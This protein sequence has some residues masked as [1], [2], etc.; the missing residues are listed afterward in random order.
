MRS[1][2]RKRVCALRADDGYVMVV[3][4]GVLL[5]ATLFSV[6][7]L[8][9]ADKD[10]PQSR[11][12]VDRKAAIGAAE[13]GL[14]YYQYHL[15]E[16]N[17]FWAACTN[18]ESPGATQPAPVNQAWNG[19]GSD[20]R[21]WRNVPGSTD[22]QYTLELL[23]APGKTACDPNNPAASMI[24]PGTGTFRI[25]ATGR[26]S[27]NRN[28]RWTYR[29]VVSTFRRRGFLD[30]L[31]FTDF[32]TSPPSVYASYGADAQA[33]AATAC[34]R[35]WRDGRGSQSYKTASGTTI[36]CTAIQFAPGDAIRG[37]MHTN[38]NILICGNPTFGRTTDSSGNAVMDKIE[39]SDPN[40]PG[41]RNACSGS[42]N[43][44]PS[45]NS[46]RIGT[47]VL[48]LPPS[49]STLSTVVKPEYTFTGT[50]TIR[51]SGSTMTVSDYG[52]P[53][54]AARNLGSMPF[55]DNG[56]IYVKQGS[57][58]SSSYNAT[59]PYNVPTGCAIA[60][61]SG[62]YSKSLTVA[63]E[64]DV[65]VR[66]L[67]S[68]PDNSGLVRQS[69]SDAIMGLIGNDHVRVYHEVKNRTNGGYSCSEDLTTGSKTNIRIDAA[70]LALNY[71][72]IVDNYYCGSPLG[73][74]TVNGVIAQR[75]RGPVGTGGSSGNSTGYVKNYGYDDRLVYRSPPYFLDPVQ[76]AW[77]VVRYDEQV[78]A[79]K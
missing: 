47:P 32:E 46:L 40:P 19:T 5:V 74:L 17:N 13:A 59:D 20:P 37:P 54:G 22:Q 21:V 41:Y 26:S 45:G 23:P 10:V 65:V 1:I 61:V 30:F 68:D 64:R 29:S 18:V 33:W 24:D 4:M 48:T 2:L 25:R 78:P 63:S 62:T 67:P 76:S 72:F 77:Q 57:C 71:S 56:V 8:A 7:A 60:Y 35:Y 75:F 58:G 44:V 3:V 11:A 43:V 51:L 66:P 73:N 70:I 15:N 14:A 36:S 31:Y 50:T 69:G 6:A 34:A 49:N 53:N 52:G 9:A 27:A 42:P 79:T 39:V 12:D 16:D 28:G 55:P 38:D